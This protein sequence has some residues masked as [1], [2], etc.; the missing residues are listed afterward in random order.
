MQSVATHIYE[1]SGRS[2]RREVAAGS[3]P[4][5]GRT[6]NRCD[7]HK[8]AEADE[9]APGPTPHREYQT[10][11]WPPIFCLGSAM[12]SMARPSE[13]GQGGCALPSQLDC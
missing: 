13:A 2:S 6:S 4:L 3:E 5:V 8:R 7:Y 12:V 1:S 10:V 9:N 11:V